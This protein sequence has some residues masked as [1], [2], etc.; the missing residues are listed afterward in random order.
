MRGY[1]DVFII[2]ALTDFRTDMNKIYTK[3]MQ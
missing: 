3:I 2:H 1:A